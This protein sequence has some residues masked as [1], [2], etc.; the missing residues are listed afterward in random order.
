MPRISTRLLPSET[1]ERHDGLVVM[2][3]RAS[4]ADEILNVTVSD[5][6]RI[7]PG[8]GPLQGLICLNLGFRSGRS[9]EY[10]HFLEDS[11]VLY[12][13]ITTELPYRK[14]PFSLPVYSV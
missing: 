12:L 7:S 14:I 1:S 8:I 2:S 4:S 9:N 6:L 13:L 3:A 10:I 5:D 11:G